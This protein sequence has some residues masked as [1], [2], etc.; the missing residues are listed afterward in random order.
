ML[1]FKRKKKQEI[2]TIPTK[3]EPEIE[4][5]PIQLYDLLQ[6]IRITVNRIDQRHYKLKYQG[7][8]LID[9]DTPTNDEPPILKGI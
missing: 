5:D 9:E 2:E 7:K 8:Q 1:W 3:N 4:I 6:D